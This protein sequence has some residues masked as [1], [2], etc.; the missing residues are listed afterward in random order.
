MRRLPALTGLRFVAAI[1]VLLF[2]A[3]LPRLAG[4]GGPAINII[5]AGYVGVS[6]FFVLSGFILAYTY[7]SPDGTLRTDHRT[8]L[9]A[10]FARVYPVYALCLVI[11]LPLFV[12]HAVVHQPLGTSLVEGIAT[13]LLLQSWIPRAACAW[14]CPGW[15]LADEALF[16]LSFPSI[17][18]LL[19]RLRHRLL[20]ITATVI[21]LVG[22]AVP[23]AYLWL[24]PDGLAT[25][26]RAESSFWLD[27][28]KFIPLFHVPEF[29]LGVVA[30]IVFVRR[31]EVDSGRRAFA[32][33]AP[34][35]F[36]VVLLTLARSDAIPYP[37]LHNGL[38][39]PLFALG[40]YA[41]ACGG[42]L[43]GRV[44]AL[45]GAVLLGEAS[46]AL[47]LVH[48]PLRDYANA[49]QKALPALQRIPT[50][51]WFAGFAAV[52]VT[53]SL[54]IFRFIEEPAR[55]YLRHGR[56]DARANRLEA[57]AQIAA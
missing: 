56:S 37:L 41:L 18:L 51:L 17:A 27:A 8:F 14:N 32:W 2:H 52:A 42:G 9:R 45:P 20:P 49:A 33:A 39:V 25:V 31:G 44:L 43:L 46:Y 40:I 6:L 53:A 48:V 23:V 54:L 12:R 15:S 30:G 50:A 28:L 35:A 3:L 19:L 22:M 47:Y 55:R 10:R 21:W 5:A 24:R 29:A 4:Y 57:G 11:S 13:P 38:L 34:V 36:G 1:G 7:V 16:Y 26:T